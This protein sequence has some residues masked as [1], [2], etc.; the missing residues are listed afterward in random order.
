[1][2][3]TAQFLMMLGAL[4]IVFGLYAIA[5]REAR[6]GSGIAGRFVSAFP[7]DAGRLFV[8]FVVAV[9]LLWGANIVTGGALSGPFDRF[10]VGLAL[11]LTIGMLIAVLAMRPR[12]AGRIEQQKNGSH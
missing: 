2:D 9:L 1:M 6:R 3:A 8:P 4:V 7:D 5:R 12:L 11:G 10:W